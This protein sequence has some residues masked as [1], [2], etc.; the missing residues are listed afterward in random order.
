MADDVASLGL[1]VDSSKVKTATSDLDKFTEA[2]KK[3]E[4]AADD[5]GK[6]GGSAADMSKKLGDSAKAGQGLADSLGATRATALAMA[7]ALGAATVG[8]LAF[9]AGALFVSEKWGAGQR[10]IERA[11]IGIGQRTGETL[12]SISKF[13]SD[14][15]SLTGL[16]VTQARQAALELTKTG[17]IAVSSLTGV[18]DAI[19]GF[20]VLTGTDATKATKEFTGALSGDLVKGAEKLNQTYGTMNS[21]TMELI[22]T[23][24]SQGNRTAAVQVIIDSIGGSNKKAADSVSFLSKAYDAL[25]NVM[26]RVM[27]GPATPASGDDGIAGRQLAALQKQR[28]GLMALPNSTGG[29][30]ILDDIN[31]QIDALQK[32]MNAFSTDAVA[33]QLNGL[34]MAGDAVIHSIIPQIDQIHK[35][36]DALKAVQDAQNTPGVVRKL[37]QDDAATRAI[38][39]QL[40]LLKDQTAESDKHNAK[41]LEIA[42]SYQG[43]STQT[44]LVLENQRH[45]LDVASAVTGEERLAA[46]EASTRADLELRG[47]DATE[48][49]AIAAGQREIAEA[50]ITAR[51]Q[52]QLLGMRDQ[53]AVAQAVTG[54]ER[55]RAEAS[56]TYNA[57]TRAGVDSMTAGAAAAEQQ[58]IAEAQVHSNMLNQVST[59]SQQTDLIRARANGSE[60]AVA[61]A[62]AY[63]NAIKAGATE[64]DAAAVSAAVL[65][66][67]VAK[68]EGSARSFSTSMKGGGGFTNG[69]TSPSQSATS[70]GLLTANAKTLL[71]QSYGSG[72]Y[73]TFLSSGGANLG[74]GSKIGVFANP[75]DQGRN[76]Q[77]GRQLIAAAEQSMDAVTRAKFEAGSFKLPASDAQSLANSFLS[78]GNNATDIQAQKAA[79][80]FVSQYGDSSSGSSTATSG[81]SPLYLSS[82]GSTN[83]GFRAAEG[84]DYTV[85]GSGPVDSVKVSG[86]VSPGE[87]MIMIPPGGAAPKDMQGGNTR[88][89]PS[90]QQTINISAPSL[91]GASDTMSQL[92]ARASRAAYAASRHR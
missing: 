82:S 30:T 8:A 40:N 5:L 89:T 39:V 58:A 86:M 3:A 71:D 64:T 42:G 34:S 18:G 65:A 85:P 27:H 68:A 14:N 19:H 37:G 54:A 36:E 25:G 31:R 55:M 12:Q 63:T 80:A 33:K 88:S 51:V 52:S 69:P 78:A 49:A 48:A 21:A 7:E 44:A 22:R 67:N 59:L 47:V 6:A 11:L 17:N 15:T 90:I 76:F 81:L 43:V 41:V 10:E 75:T 4:K 84:M 91:Q 9:G 45:Q 32:K 57:L 1:S 79:D 56:A 50:Q 70:D 38:Q 60:A 28:E 35:L 24:E 72:G 66:N 73:T 20:A 62:Q 13:T 53:L 83:L 46:Q 92:A 74:P 61:A 87:R 29:T 26:D 16:S 2:S 23:L 77:Y